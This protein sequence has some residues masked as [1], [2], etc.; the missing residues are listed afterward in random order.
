M[1]DEIRLRS[2]LQR[3]KVLSK[4][5]ARLFEFNHI[6]CLVLCHYHRSPPP[7]TTRLLALP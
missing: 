5:A 4:K 6:L 7:H 3:M 1:A 2:T